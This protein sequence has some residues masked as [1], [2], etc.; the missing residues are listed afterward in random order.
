MVILLSIL[1]LIV[2]GFYIFFSQSKFGSLPTGK[3]KE[4]IFHSPNFRNGKFQNRSLTPDL[5]EGGTYFSVMKE[6]FFN[7]SDRSN[8]KMEIPSIKTD[9]HT[10]EG[11]ALIWMG[12]SSYYIQI[13][14]TRIL[15]DPVLSGSASPVRFTTRS[16]KGADAYRAEDIPPIDYLFITHDHWDHLD[17]NTLIKLK[18]RIK[19]IITGLGTGAHLLRWHFSGDRIKEMDWNESLTL[20]NGFQVHSIPA[21]H[22]SGRG[23]KRNQA[24][25]LS[26]L[27]ETAGMKIFLGGD[28]G[29]DAHFKEAHD[30]FG[31][32][33]LA[34]LECGQYN[35][36]WKHIHMMPEEVVQA[37][38]DLG[39]KQLIPVHWSK[40]S[41]SLH[42]WDEPIKRVIT[43]A[44]GTG[45][46]VLHPMIGEPVNLRKESSYSAWWENID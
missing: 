42:D 13:Q 9:L 43:A 33:D 18:P 15:V 35:R 7:K 46:A 30:R 28:S 26:F 34:I 23:L 4:R 38:R 3:S 17:Q 21:R 16:F 19:N 29:Y 20:E 40:F 25:W 10:L 31:D 2:L 32:V 1:L 41:L 24:L 5:T 36:Y 22:F 6:F 27:L 45:I 14:G 8:P 39:A 11:D 12:H 44:S 37:A